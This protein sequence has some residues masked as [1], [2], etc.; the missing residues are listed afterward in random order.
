MGDTGN[1][2]VNIVEMETAILQM[3]NSIESFREIGENAFSAEL[4]ELEPMNSDF[5]EKLF[6]VLE[7]VKGWNLMILIQNLDTFWADAATILENLKSTDEAHNV[8]RVKDS[9]G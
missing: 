9:N 5:V 8:E 4:A 2:N 3:G 7:G 1:L 6:R